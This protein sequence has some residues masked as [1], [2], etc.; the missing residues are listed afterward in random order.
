MLMYGFNNGVPGEL[1]HYRQNGGE[2]S[3]Y[4]R[5]EDNDKKMSWQAFGLR[6]AF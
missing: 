6:A 4:G 1:H 3:A 2:L 5:D